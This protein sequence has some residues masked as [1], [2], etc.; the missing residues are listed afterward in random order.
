M[1]ILTKKIANYIASQM[2]YD[3]N[4]RAVIAYG[5]LAIFQM[6]FIFATISVIGLIFDFWFECMI[7]FLGIG[8]IR[9]STGGAHSETM[10]GCILISVLS[11]TILSAISRYLIDFTLDSLTNIGIST[12]IYILCFIFFYIKVPVDSPKKPIVKPE[13]IRRLR[14][15][16]FLILTV[17]LIM[18]FAFIFLAVRYN[19][20][21][22]LV[23][24]IR[25]TMLWQI[26]TLTKTGIIFLGK[27]DSRLKVLLQL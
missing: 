5:L 18:S 23:M 22:S 8:I 1:E 9:K 16:S 7:I 4:K 15:Q 27:F 10:Y 12:V 13:K 11:I 21:Y 20:F 14:K 3:Y 25:L 6:V 26:F 19:R 2:N 17:L 24:V